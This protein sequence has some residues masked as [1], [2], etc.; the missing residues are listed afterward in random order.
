[1]KNKFITLLFVVI[2][3][4]NPLNLTFADE[5]IFKV[6][7]LEI[8][9]NGKVYKGNNRGKVTT[10]NQTEIISNNFEYLKKTN[11]LEAN[12]DVI[13]T[14]I[15]NNIIINAEKIFYLKNEEKIYTVGKTLIKVSDEYYIEGS[16]LTLLKNKMI[17]SSDKITTISDN[18]SNFYRLKKFEY[19]INEEIL[20]G[21]KIEVTTN[22]KKNKS[23][24]YFFETGFIN[25]KENKFLAKNINVKMHKSLYGNKENDP[26]I[27]AV[28][29]Y[30]DKY[31][32]FYDKGVFTSCKKTD[33]CPPWKINAEKIQHDKVKK[34]VIYNNAWL[35]LYD[36]PV[37]YFPKFF[38]PDPSVKRQSGFLTPALGS[39]STL[40]SSFYAPYFYVISESEDITIK[41]TLF[42][43]NK[44]L[45][46]NEFRQKTK[47]SIT[48]TDFSVANRNGTKSH[49][50]TNTEMD[51]SLDNYT[52]SLLEIN[53][54][55][56][57]N[58]NYLKLFDLKSP[59]LLESKDV[60]ESRIK[61]DLEHENYDLTTSVIM[62][63]T[64]SDSNTDR[65]Q[66]V[67]PSYNFSK[68]FNLEQLD[69]S[70]NFNSSGQN[71][72]RDTN[73]YT[74]SL[75][76]NLN[77][78]TNNIFFDNGVKTN[79]EVLLKNIN[80][81]GKNNL[82]YKESL[83]SELMSAYV[84]NTS[85]PL[86]KNTEKNRNT[87]EP[88]LSFRFSPHDMK[89]NSAQERR[90]SINNIFGADRLG[91]GDSFESGESLTMGLNF[92]QE[93]VKIKDEIKEVSDFFD[94]KLATVLRL[95]EEKNI[96][97]NST[98]NKKQSNLFGQL[99][100]RPNSHVSLNYDF[101][102]T[103]NL[104]M[105]EYNS[106]IANFNYKSFNTSFN[107]LEERGVIGQTNIIQNTTSYRFDDSNSIAFNTR[108]NKN[109]NLTEYYDLVYRY[110]NDCL[111]AGIQYKKNYYSDSGIEPVDELFFTI[112]IVPLTTF[113]PDKL[114]K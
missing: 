52:S 61:L 97:I 11:R 19:S 87:L 1:M 94:F 102:V 51:L 60:L 35:E 95:N 98:L 26:R 106:V 68:N 21:E 90:M 16:D 20:K 53:Y 38:H 14:D 70:F 56:T 108:K 10:D 18:F 55:K 57:S 109:L 72:L 100:L 79:F 67:L 15:E 88:K 111:I 29:G 110:Q 86:V 48:L 45:I 81:V 36:Y 93:R 63:E 32:S 44:F 76:N 9:N 66:Y 71:S 105:I 104:D 43:N 54:E 4:L 24:K 74:T 69:G 58:D 62:Y 49:F 37:L 75:S 112:T 83:Q 73:V 42:D 33:K 5:F 3:N 25:L 17:L 84:Y 64:L 78:D 82:Q 28:S 77:Y 46:Q 22:Y 85:L 89:N 92:K 65:Y 101:S 50:F 47:N 40:G 114:L 13:L 30:G 27:N 91:M 8:T 23:D 96:P 31:N 113:S 99:K 80:T 7:N 107:I 39:S 59:L 12:G 2:L 103:D 41:P 34:R 6:G